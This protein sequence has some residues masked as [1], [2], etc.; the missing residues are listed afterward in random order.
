M[1]GDKSILPCLSFRI[2]YS[3]GNL[4]KFKLR[5]GHVLYMLLLTYNMF[6]LIFKG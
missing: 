1:R 5:L 6:S 4:V 2:S 3:L